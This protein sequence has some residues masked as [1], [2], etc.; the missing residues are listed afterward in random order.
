VGQI[1][2]L[3]GQLAL[4]NKQLAKHSSTASQPSELLDQRDLLLRELSTLIAVNTK[5]EANGAVV[6]SMGDTFDQ[7]ILVKNNIS[8]DITVNSS[9]IDAGKLEFVIDAYGTPESMPGIASGKIGGVMSFRD[10]VLKPASDSL[11]NLATALVREVNRVHRDGVD[12]EGQL[13]GDLFGFAKDKTEKASGMDLLVKDA[14]RVAAAGQFR[15]IDEPLNSGSAQAQISY[16]APQYAGPTE[17]QGDLAIGLKPQLGEE[18]LKIQAGIG[19]THVGAVKA[20]TQNLTLTLVDPSPT[21]QIQVMT[22]DGRHLIGSTNLSSTLQT[23]LLQTGNGMESGA[24]YDAGMLNASG[25]VQYVD[26]RLSAIAN[27]G[28]AQSAQLTGGVF[29]STFNVEPIGIPANTFEL[30]GRSLPA[31]KIG[32]GLINLQ[33]VV[34]WI[35]GSQTNLPVTEQ[36][37]AMATPDGKLQISRPVG[38]TTGSIELKLGEK[39]GSK[40]LSMFGFAASSISERAFPVTPAPAVLAGGLFPDPG[41]SGNIKAGTYSLNGTTLPALDLQGG[42]LTLTKAVQWINNAAVPGIQALG[43]DG[44][45]QIQRTDGDGY[46]TIALA[47]GPQGEPQQLERLG[48]SGATRYLDMDIFLGA[49][50][51]VTQLVEFNSVTGKALPT[52]AAPAVL[53]SRPLNSGWTLPAGLPAG[54]ITLNGINLGSLLPPDNLE[55][56]ATWIN[57]SQTSLPPSKQVTASVGSFEVQVNGALETFNRLELRRAST[58]TSDDIRLGIGQNGRPADLNA[59]GFDTSLHVNGSASDDLLVFVTDSSVDDSTVKMQAS[60]SEPSGSLKQFLRESPIEVRFVNSTQYEIV[61]TRT[62]SVLAE[63][64]LLTDTRSATPSILYRGLKLEFST[65]PKSGDRFTIDGNRDGIGNNETMLALVALE[66]ERLMPGGLTITEAYIERVNQ[67]GNVAR[68]AAISEQAL[69]VVYQQAQEARDG[70]SGV[71]L[72]EEASALVRFQQAY[73]ANAKVMQTAMALF[74]SILQIR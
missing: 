37:V 25:V 32:G 13:G 17:L 58:N 7:G 45:L 11:D 2:A 36:V 60:M 28:K 1:N 59:L 44:R 71:S 3:S 9:K 70:I 19:Y 26:G 73:Q 55:D 74:D 68:Q 67:V 27:P 52:V 62:R 57:N 56:I 41:T 33:E 38:N 39:A 20:G 22:R 49:M 6:V 63:R 5:Y 10:Q 21:Q 8:R 61:D 16:Q 42:V 50:A 66:S 15:V 24:T 69:E 72:D 29:P 43:E 46:K 30:N 53:S 31:F 47:L 64:E 35:N 18:R 65:H 12:A 54:A 34:S 4:M 40:T 23:S 51:P 48:F 14:N